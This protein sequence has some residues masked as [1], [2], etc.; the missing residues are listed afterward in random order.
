MLLRTGLKV[1]PDHILLTSALDLYIFEEFCVII[2]LVILDVIMPVARICLSNFTIFFP[3][4]SYHNF[5]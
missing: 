1:V 2:A 5:R 3:V 4:S